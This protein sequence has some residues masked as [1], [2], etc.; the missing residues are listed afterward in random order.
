MGFFYDNPDSQNFFNEAKLHYRPCGQHKPFT[1][2]VPV[3]T[4]M[5]VCLGAVAAYLMLQMSNS[6]NTSGF[7]PAAV[8]RQVAGM[9]ATPLQTIVTSVGTSA[10]YATQMAE[11]GARQ[12][13]AMITGADTTINAHQVFSSIPDALGIELIDS[14]GSVAK[15]A[16]EKLLRQWVADHPKACIM[17]FAHWCVHCK[18]MMPRLVAT[19]EQAAAE[20]SDAK[21]LMVNAESVLSTAFVGPNKLFHLTHYPTI[22]CVYNKQLMVFPSPEEAF[23]AMKSKSLPPAAPS[24]E[25]SMTQPPAAMAALAMFDAPEQE[26]DPF[27]NF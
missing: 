16:N 6:T 1:V 5:Y 8:P 24:E 17:F 21:F 13:S 9:I 20:G 22:V 18:E 27:E 3:D 26:E 4:V 12:V 10:R 11:S 2:S 15:A 23:D 7:A 14:A 19:A 25:A